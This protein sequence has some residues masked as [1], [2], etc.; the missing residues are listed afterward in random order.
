MSNLKVPNLRREV[1]RAQGAG[2]IKFERKAEWFAADIAT[3]YPDNK[4]NGS[5]HDKYIDILHKAS[6]YRTKEENQ[7]HQRE[8]EKRQYILR[9]A[10]LEYKQIVK[11]NDAVSGFFSLSK[12]ESRVEDEL[13][14]AFVELVKFMSKTMCLR[15]DDFV[16]G[17]HEAARVK[18]YFQILDQLDAKVHDKFKQNTVVGCP[19]IARIA[20]DLTGIPASWFIIQDRKERY[21]KLKQQLLK[22]MFDKTREI[23]II[24][25]ALLRSKTA[26]RPLGMFLFVGPN[27]V[28]KAE[29]IRAIAGELYDDEDRLVLIDMSKYAEA[30]SVSGL[31]DSI[32]RTVKTMP[33]S[34]LLFDRIEM[35]HSSV[36]DTL[37]SVLRAREN[38][39]IDFQ[40]TLIIITLSDYVGAIRFRELPKLVDDVIAVELPFDL[41]DCS[42]ILLR[43]WAFQ[44]TKSNIEG[45]RPAVIICP[46]KSALIEMERNA[47]G[48]TV[49]KLERWMEEKVFS[50]LSKIVS[51]YDD[52]NGDGVAENIIIYIDKEEQT[53]E[54]SFN[55]E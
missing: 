8:L 15:H 1:E 35:A 49:K 5:V 22:R 27:R 28:G 52:D 42:R 3:K 19:E 30:D 14:D 21:M 50:V 43:E 31:V 13:R 6:E 4:T 7:T 16:S 2:G 33:C 44:R 47:G 10:L 37:S 41:K 40:N 46:S 12:V 48:C 32:T 54:L 20:C 18:D 29:L 55:F 25:Q 24:V 11:D 51:E 39:V 9:R 45:N 38:G 36:I 17:V 53:G 34:V 23:E 26:G